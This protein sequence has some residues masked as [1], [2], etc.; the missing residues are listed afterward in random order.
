MKKNGVSPANVGFGRLPGYIGYQVR[1]TQSAIFRDISRSIGD[2]GVTPGEFSLLTM[3]EANPGLNSITLARLYRLDKATLSLSLKRLV[4]RGLIRTERNE[5]DRRYYSLRLTAAGRK[6]LQRVTR[7]IE[8]QE[9]AMDAVLKAG[10]RELI[11]DLLK[12][13]AGAFDR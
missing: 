7:R 3:V 4:G 1:Q 2:L 12:R 8:K 11:L 9:R 10:E 6:L 5:R 13:I